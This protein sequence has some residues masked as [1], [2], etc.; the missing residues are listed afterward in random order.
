M[1]PWRVSLFQKHAAAAP[2]ETSRGP[3]RHATARGGDL[4]DF[5][6]LG[7]A[8]LAIE[9]SRTNPFRGIGRGS[10][11]AALAVA[12]A[13]GL[14]ASGWFG[15]EYLHAQ[16]LAASQLASAHNV[17]L[18][19]AS[20][21]DALAQLR[22]RLAAADRELNS[23]KSRAVAASGEAQRQRAA[24]QQATESESDRV[25]A[26]TRQLHLT[27]A[28]RVTL[29][30]RLSM[31]QANA[32]QGHAR[33]LQAEAGLDEWQRK[34]KQL[35]E[36]RDRAA[37]ERDRLH[38]A[39]GSL[40]QQLA[41]LQ[42]RQAAPAPAPRTPA[43]AAAPRT[44]SIPAAPLA[45]TQVAARPAAP[46]IA[47]PQ[48]TAAARPAAPAMAPARTAAAPRLAPSVAVATGRLGQFE[49]VL[50][51]AGVDVR[52]LFAGFGADDAEGGPFVPVPRGGVPHLSAAKLAAL[53]RIVGE[54][55]VSAPLTS[56]H[57]SSP[58]GVRGDPMN[59][60]HE[61][62]TGLDM[63]APYMSPVYATAPG[64]VTYAGHRDD[65]G[66]VVEINHGNGISTRY[67]HLHRYVVSVGQRVA[68][69]QMIGYLGSS[70]RATGPHVHYEVLVNGEP[71]DP[72]KFLGLAKLM[73][74][75]VA[76]RR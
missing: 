61:F 42:A 37:Q 22:D 21:Q 15:V 49:R 5:L 67:A 54:L 16:R 57:V 44:S 48:P 23:A 33:Q 4:T 68:A 24:T 59:G 3:R 2:P 31:A 25:A 11:A 29:M 72:E 60:D 39:L 47:A 26:L 62:H 64:V 13:V 75:T 14:G 9:A 52:R 58:F 19:N 69:H 35:T 63:V 71:Q 18:A 27:E 51:S 7:S 38:A 41:A 50:A 36:D 56:Y 43:P 76:A 55:P 8:G 70:G 32:A 34:V 17:E 53:S 6:R 74:V 1:P 30:A 65:Y 12:A 10:A 46:A 73:P 40:Q 20:L 66:R 45:R 28:Q